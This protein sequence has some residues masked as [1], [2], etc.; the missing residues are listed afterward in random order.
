M[1]RAQGTPY[2]PAG[3][4]LGRTPGITTDRGGT[5]PRIATGSSP[6]TSRITVLAVI[7]TF[8]PIT[9]SRPIRTPSTR[10]AREPTNTPSSI[11]T[12]VAPGGSRTPPTPTPPARC[13]SRPICAHD[14]T[15][16]QVST[17][18]P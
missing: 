9:A 17:I 12:G 6:V 2:S 14:P 3:N 16:A 5:L 15:V 4:F 18:E 1:I 11:T 13:T 8:A 7:T 10:I